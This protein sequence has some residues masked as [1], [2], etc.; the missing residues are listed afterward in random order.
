VEA[1]FGH[2][3]GTL[4]ELSLPAGPSP[5]RPCAPWGGQSEPGAAPCLCWLS[6]A[7]DPRR[8]LADADRVRLAD[9]VRSI[10]ADRQGEGLI[11]TVPLH[12]AGR[13][14]INDSRGAM[15]QLLEFASSIARSCTVVTAFP[16]AEPHLL[17]S[18]VA[19]FNEELAVASGEDAHDP[20]LV[21][22]RQ[23]DPVWCG[24]SVPLQA[25]ESW[26]TRL[27]LQP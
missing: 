7:F 10:Q 6:C 27:W 1:G 25:N 17:D 23:G 2:V 22:G 12:E 14:E 15:Y 21:L 16:D 18:C 4:L 11:V 19:M 13:A 26:R 8:G 24:G 5:T 9:Q 3:A 20:I